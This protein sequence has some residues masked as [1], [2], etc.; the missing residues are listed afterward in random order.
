MNRYIKILI[1]TTVVLISTHSVFAQ[2]VF[3]L[4][5]SGTAEN[6]EFKKN[7]GNGQVY[8][9]NELVFDGIQN[10]KIEGIA[11]K[12]IG[13]YNYIDVCSDVCF[14]YVLDSNHD[15]F[16]IS[17][18]F[19]IFPS[20]IRN[21]EEYIVF[22]STFPETDEWAISLFSKYKNEHIGA[23]YLTGLDINDVSIENDNIYLIS[24]GKSI[25]EYEIISFT[26]DSITKDRENS[27]FNKKVNSI[28]KKY[29]LYVLGAIVLLIFIWFIKKIK[30]N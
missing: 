6:V 2:E 17:L 3:H 4:W 14:T 20:F 11:T 22:G 10:Q 18:G 16:R 28:F 7:N 9:D 25:K 29:Y 13:E 12:K 8:V 24:N 5:N 1:T 21:F 26:K 23:R 30:T 27:R 19:K 15:K